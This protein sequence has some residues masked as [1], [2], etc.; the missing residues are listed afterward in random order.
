MTVSTNRGMAKWL[1]DFIESIGNK[2]EVKEAEKVTTAEINVHDLQKVVWNDETFY[3]MFDDKGAVV[4]NEFGNEVTTLQNVSTIEQVDE[5]LNSKQVVAE[6][7]TDVSTSEDDPFEEEL[8]KVSSYL[9]QEI[10]ETN[11]NLDLNNKVA[12]LERTVDSLNKKIEALV[13]QEYARTNPGAIYD[14][15][16]ENAEQQHFEESSAKG[17]EQINI[18]KSV[19]LTTMEGRVSLRDKLK[20]EIEQILNN[21]TPEEEPTEEVECEEET[22]EEPSG[23]EEQ[24]D[25]EEVCDNEEQCDDVNV[26]VEVEEPVQ[27]VT[28]EVTEEQ[29]PEETE[30]DKEED[31]EKV[32][33]LSSRDFKIFAKQICPDCG[34][35]TLVKSKAVGN[36][37]GVYCKSCDSEFA[38]NTD[39]EEVFKKN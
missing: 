27:D 6:E 16:V 5:V 23:D 4:Y 22:C 35:E 37:T 31:K 14:I 19:D 28:E 39:S 36:I 10:E 34:E 18:E 21:E 38:V 17:Q 9:N 1:D 24:S 32:V 8:Q 2:K 12:E 29:L 3:V 25:N 11:T 13:Q 20:G 33:K 15:G 30:E 7:E 26:E